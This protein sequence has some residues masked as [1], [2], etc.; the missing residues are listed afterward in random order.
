MDFSISSLLRQLIDKSRAPEEPHIF[1]VFDLDSTLFN[2]TFRNEA[3]LKK[4]ASIDENKQRFPHETVI[5][6]Q[7]I[8]EHKDW[9]IKDIL[10]RY[11]IDVSGEFGK[12]IKHFWQ[13]EFFCN[14]NLHVDQPYP[15]AVEYVNR[16]YQSGADVIYLT[17]RDTKRMR[18]GTIQ[19]LKYWKFPIEQSRTELITKP[20]SAFKDENYKVE[21]LKKILTRH[22]PNEVWFFENEPVITHE[23]QKLLP[24]INIVFIDSVHSRRAPTPKD[25]PKV[26]M[27]FEWED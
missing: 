6:R 20:D 4:F 7:A 8:A 17:G 13:K 11:G 26:P 1:A 27:N 18:P 15:G 16:L 10:I 9:G 12:C 2:V 19:S 23:V 25:L 5:I 14:D 24:Q 22:T 3:I 21:E